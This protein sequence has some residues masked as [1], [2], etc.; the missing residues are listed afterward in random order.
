M[1]LARTCLPGVCP[2]NLSGGPCGPP[3]PPVAAEAGA[4]DEKRQ[5]HVPHIQADPA[6][7]TALQFALRKLSNARCQEVFA[8]F[9]DPAGRTLAN[10]LEALG[11]T[12]SSYLALIRFYDAGEEGPCR[13]N[14]FAFTARG[15]HAVYLCGTRFR[16]RV[17]QSPG[18]AAA[19]LIHEELHSLGLGENPPSSEEITDRVLDRCGV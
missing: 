5:A 17:R 4:G 15:S 19:V 12:A 1:T 18:R 3:N 6:V 11:E 10:N 8:D 16:A 2:S 14:V 7:Q 9:H 13:K